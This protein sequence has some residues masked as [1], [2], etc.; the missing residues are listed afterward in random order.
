MT[1]SENEKRWKDLHGD[2]KSQ[3]YL[4]PEIKDSWERCN[5]NG[6]LPSLLKPPV[7]H[8]SKTLPQQG[9]G[10]LIKA[11]RI[12]SGL[13]LQFLAPD[14]AIL[15]FDRNTC[16]LNVV[17]FPDV[18]KWINSC[19]IGEGTLWSEDLS[20]TNAASLG[21]ALV[22]PITVVGYE[23]YCRFAIG[24]ACAFAPIVDKRDVIIGGIGI[25]GPAS[26]YSQDTL[27]IAMMAA[28]YLVEKV[29]GDRWNDIINESI[30]EGVV[31]IDDK[32]RIFYM[33]H[34]CGRI[35][36]CRAENTF[37][38]PFSD[39]I[40]INK[41]DNHYFWSILKHG[42]AVQD[43]SVVVTVGKE[44][45]HFTVTIKPLDL[46]W[47]VLSG[48]IIVIQENERINRKDYVGHGALIK[49]NDIIGNDPKFVQAKDYALLA[50]SSNSNILLVGE[51]GT[52]KDVF[53]Q[54]IHNESPRRNGPFLAINCAALPREL[55]ASE[56]FGYD[57]GA[58]TGARKGGNMGKFELADQGTIFLDEIGDMPLDL[59]ATLLRVIEE[60]KIMRVGGSKAIP[61]NVRVIAS[62]NKDVEEEVARNRFRLDL[63]Y[64]LGVIRITIPP[65]RERPDDVIL[66]AK[67]FTKVL[68]RKL[69]KP[70]RILTQEVLD[71]FLDYNWPGNVRELQNVL[72]GAIQMSSCSFITKAL[73][74]HYFKQ[75]TKILQVRYEYSTQISELPQTSELPQ[76][77]MI[78]SYL[79]K[80]DYNKSKTARALGISRKTLYK[81]IQEYNLDYVH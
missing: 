70:G 56:L 3:A 76:K 64:R 1:D 53:A 24:H 15:L 16:V 36:K 73:F 11:F 39:V 81:R 6:V 31:A 49:S 79:E 22:K 75:G 61:V 63:Y 13:L 62:T 25:L 50:A 46:P 80:F 57:D 68:C 8:T 9:S 48:H 58:F 14:N 21:L 40:D 27:G 29:T 10:Y 42:Y 12:I 66:L 51:S 18:L 34:N 67:H 45:I 43:E 38:L 17:A 32:N 54:A 52:G 72:E 71:A 77:Q 78:I 47:N 23:H 33:N 41:P 20:G 65:L 30:S 26:T 28:L 69:N 35:L 44:K 2:Y 60:K 5:Q 37:L 4:R 55:I 74:D 7:N 59:Q 19:N